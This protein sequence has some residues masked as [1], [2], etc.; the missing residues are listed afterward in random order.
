MRPLW[1]SDARAQTRGTTR[2]LRMDQNQERE[3]MN[4]RNRFEMVATRA[5][6]RWQMCREIART[7]GWCA[8]MRAMTLGVRG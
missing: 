7:A 4:S 6:V 1:N 2:H 3:A 8:A 5:D